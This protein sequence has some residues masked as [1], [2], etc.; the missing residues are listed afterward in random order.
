MKPTIP[1]TIPPEKERDVI[2]EG[3]RAPVSEATHSRNWGGT[4][5]FAYLLTT[6]QL[7]PP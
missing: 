1:V 4:V 6:N 7:F 2:Q 5:P 3:N